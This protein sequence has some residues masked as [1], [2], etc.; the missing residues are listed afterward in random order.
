M[1]KIIRRLWIKTLKALGLYSVRRSCYGVEIPN[2]CIGDSVNS[3]KYKITEKQQKKVRDWYLK[4]LPEKCET[5]TDFKSNWIGRN[6]G[7]AY[8]SGS[9][10]RWNGFR[11]CV[12]NNVYVRLY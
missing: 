3:Y 1:F 12:G 11:L 6:F 4:N 5:I 2:W 7:T 8:Y 10:K 9:S